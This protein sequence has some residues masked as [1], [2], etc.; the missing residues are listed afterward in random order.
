MDMGCG[1][2]VDIPDNEEESQSFAVGANTE[3]GAPGSAGYYRRHLIAPGKNSLERS[4]KSSLLSAKVALLYS[5]SEEMDCVKALIRCVL[6][7]RIFNVYSLVT[8]KV[9]SKKLTTANF[10]RTLDHEIK[11]PFMLSLSS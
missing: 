4:D 1:R 5:T 10:K 8:R 3:N 2:S 11:S 7:R 6:W 9:L